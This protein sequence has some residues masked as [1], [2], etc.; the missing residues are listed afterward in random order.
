M[1]LAMRIRSRADYFQY[2]PSQFP[3][4]TLQR[5]VKMCAPVMATHMLEFRIDLIATVEMM[6]HL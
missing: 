2:K 3:I 4:Q 5:N 6:S 1:V